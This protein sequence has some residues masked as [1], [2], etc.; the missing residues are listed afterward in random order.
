MKLIQ[1]IDIKKKKT[2]LR[3]L[4]SLNETF[5]RNFSQLSVKGHVFL[6]LENKKEPFE[7][8]LT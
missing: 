1:E 8:E 3:T 2:F 6:E 4:A 7:G 5:S